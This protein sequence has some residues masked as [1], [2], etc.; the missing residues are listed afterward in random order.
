MTAVATRSVVGSMAEKFG[1]EPGPFEATVRASCNAEKLTREQ[2]A[3]FLLVAREHNLNPITREIFAFPGKSGVV[4]V[5]SID[6]WLRI[7]NSHPQMDGLVLTDLREGGKLIGV[8][9]RI[10]R[11]DRQHPIE[12]TEYLDECARETDVWRK[13][14]ARML[15]HKATIQCARYAFGFA[16]I[17]DQDEA[18]RIDE[19]QVVTP[20]I[21]HKSAYQSRKDGDWQRL[22]KALCAMDTLEDIETFKVVNADA[23]N[24]MPK[25]WQAELETLAETRA[26]EIAARDAAD[27]AAERTMNAHV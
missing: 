14:P 1:M 17:Y 5:V 8:Q 24:A 23:I 9:A 20:Q 11:K 26:E 2:F 19:V 15:R 4:P 12:V 18:E 3:A 16:G 7:I 22:T 13:W 10:H 27:R 21:E 6:G 25:N